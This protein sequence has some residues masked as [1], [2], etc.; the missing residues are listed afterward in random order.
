RRTD[1][2]TLQRVLPIVAA[3]AAIGGAIYHV[4]A[5]GPVRP[6]MAEVTKPAVSTGNTLPERPLRRQRR[7]RELV[8]DTSPRYAR[9]RAARISTPCPWRCAAGSRGTRSRADA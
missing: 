2:K 7:R 4:S 9:G 5:Q 6:A 3:L 8:R 1:M